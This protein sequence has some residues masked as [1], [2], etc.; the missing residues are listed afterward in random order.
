MPYYPAG[1]EVVGI[2]FSPAMLRRATRRRA[3]LGRA[4]ELREMDV[5]VTDFP[6]DHFDAVVA[7]Y[8][9]CVLDDDRQRPALE[10]LARICKPGGEIRLLDYT[11]SADPAR[12]FV[13]RITAPWVR[14]LYGAA[15][16]RD[17]ERHAAAAGLELVE[18]RF[19]LGDV[20]RL[21][22]VRRAA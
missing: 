13:M 6:D 8:L 16:D 17:T 20:I 9:F 12:R 14:W 4:V 10:G 1:G 3:R 5:C 22:V 7:T 18:R 19:V 2:D 15:F 11:L 21:L